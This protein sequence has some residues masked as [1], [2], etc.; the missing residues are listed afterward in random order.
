MRALRIEAAIANAIE[1]GR[2]DRFAPVVFISNARFPTTASLGRPICIAKLPNFAGG[3]HRHAQIFFL[4]FLWPSDPVPQQHT[5][6]VDS[7]KRGHSL[8]K[9]QQGHNKVRLQSNDQE[10]SMPF[11]QERMSLQ[12]YPVASW[13]TAT[14]PKDVFFTFNKIDECRPS[15]L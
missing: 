2:S 4:P 11:G 12:K 10:K 5:H 9:L 7:E 6:L 15:H 3:A 13:R 1:T 14:V 8:K